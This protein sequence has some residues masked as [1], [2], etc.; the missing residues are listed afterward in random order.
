MGLLV[1]AGEDEHGHPV[2]RLIWHP[3]KEATDWQHARFGPFE[4]SPAD[5]VIA[6]TPNSSLSFERSEYP[7]HSGPIR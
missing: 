7:I 2:H 4:Q 5:A 6:I 1:Q 3:R